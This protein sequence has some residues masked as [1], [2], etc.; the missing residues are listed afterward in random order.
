MASTS[1]ALSK[2]LDRVKKSI[3]QFPA[4]ASSLNDATDQLGRSIGHLDAVL[5]KFSLGI[6]TWVPFG[7]S[8][9][10]RPSYYH[11]DLGYAKIAGKWGIAVRTVEGDTRAEEDDRVELWLFPEA[12]RYLRVQA[13]EKIPDLLEAML[14]SAAELSKRMIEKA[15]EVDLL[16]TSINLITGVPNPKV[17]HYVP[18]KIAKEYK[19]TPQVA[20]SAAEGEALNILVAA[21]R[22]AQIAS[23]A[24]VIS[25]SAYE[26]LEEIIKSQSLAIDAINVHV[27]QAAD[28][29]A[30]FSDAVPGV[31]DVR[32][33]K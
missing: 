2:K 8:P 33:Q 32:M 10:T 13:V 15:E 1:E 31:A 3:E 16:G 4:A 24:A 11:E 22:E 5:K 30:A 19:R 17:S 23:G 6:P 14:A 12:P 29:A 25:P 18:K 26:T 9:G 21:T 20:P 7:G 27:Q 28:S